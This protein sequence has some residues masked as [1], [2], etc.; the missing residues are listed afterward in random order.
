[1]ATHRPAKRAK[2]L[3]VP[4]NFETITLEM[5][6]SE[7]ASSEVVLPSKGHTDHMKLVKKTQNYSYSVPAGTLPPPPDEL[8]QWLDEIIRDPTYGVV[9]VCV[10]LCVCGCCLSHWHLSLFSLF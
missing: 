2:M 9:C 8:L 6:S 10:C 4:V 7:V 5:A 3:P 1:M